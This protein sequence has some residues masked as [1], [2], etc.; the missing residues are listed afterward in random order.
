[1]TEFILT[2]PDPNV[3]PE[4]EVKAKPLCYTHP[5]ITE[6]NLIEVLFKKNNQTKLRCMHCRRRVE[7]NKLYNKKVWEVHKRELTDYYLR[8]VLSNN[9]KI[10][11]DLVPQELIDAKRAIIQLKRM[12]EKYE[13]PFMRCSSH[14]ALYKDDVIKAGVTYGKQRYKCRECMK[15]LHKNHYELNKLK[16]Q[17]K[18][19]EYKEKDIEKWRNIK[20]ESFKRNKHKYV[21]RQKI[22]HAN[23]S[24]KQA[25]ELADRYIKRQLAR[26]AN[27]SHKDIPQEMI[28]C[29]RVLMQLKR[30]IKRNTFEQKLNR[31]E[32]ENGD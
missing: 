18:H 28:D 5:W 17:L 32:T 8:K 10:R 27:L 23:L 15:E 12:V 31:K 22:S 16:V 14:G 3:L 7:E 11:F 6:E 29:K 13:E 30:G 25:K 4:K 9:F 1:M 24:K 21:E 2:N 19:K 20:K 26:S